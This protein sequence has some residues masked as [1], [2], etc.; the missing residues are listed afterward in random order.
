MSQ[1]FFTL[2]AENVIKENTSPSKVTDLGLF[3]KLK[4]SLI[5]VLSAVLGY[6]MG[7][8]TVIWKDLFFLIVGGTLLTGA[9]NGF[10]QVWERNIDKKMSRTMNRPLPT[11]RMSVTQGLTI[12]SIT[13]VAGIAILWFLLNPI[14]GLLGFI[15]L[16][17][18]V[19]LY[20]PLKAHSPIAVF[21][22]AF[23]GAI[24][25][26][27]GYVAAT[28]DFGVE[29][30]SLFAVQFMWQF[31]HFWAIAWVAHEDYL[32]AGYRLLPFRSGQNKKTAFQILLY[33]LFLIPVSLLPWVLPMNNPMVGNVAMIV[34]VAAG[35][36]FAWLA[37]KLYKSNEMKDAK[38]LMFASFIYLPVVQLI[39]VIDKC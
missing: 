7:T 34:T 16:F 6:F 8:D 28:A 35:L 31:P 21:V 1:I 30:G 27:L 36:T 17:F 39:Y 12:A 26:M 22:G 33:S 10:N 20:T 29:P 32:K 13:A 37:Y 11:G 23:P 14:S 5:V 9:S 24:P 15:A 4:L 38:T 19:L 25:P 18:Y 2:K 3:F